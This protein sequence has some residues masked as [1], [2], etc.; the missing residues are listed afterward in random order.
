L[1]SG[2]CSVNDIRNLMDNLH[3]QLEYREFETAVRAPTDSWAVLD[4][5]N[6]A[7]EP[8]PRPLVS[9]TPETA[10]ASLFPAVA[11][12]QPDRGPTRSLLGRYVG[13]GAAEV[14]P[15]ELVRQM[16]LDDVFVRLA[17]ARR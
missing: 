4:R 8:Q 1:K 6:R 3:T 2:R 12:R 16:P 14:E 5:I 15:A 17:S 7:P 11:D 10:A 9:T 13:G